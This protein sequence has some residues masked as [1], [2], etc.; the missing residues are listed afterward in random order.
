MGKE[1]QKGKGQRY[2]FM[3]ANGQNL[4]QETGN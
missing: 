2:S 1:V 3:E 4:K